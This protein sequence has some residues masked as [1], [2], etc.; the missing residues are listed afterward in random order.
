MSLALWLDEEEEQIKK[1]TDEKKAQ[2]APKCACGHK[3]CC[4]KHKNSQCACQK[5]GRER[6]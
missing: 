6:D 1:S 4:G 5:Q 2:D 3:V